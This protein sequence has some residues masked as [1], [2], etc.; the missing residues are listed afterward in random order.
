MP[1]AAFLIARQGAAP[2]A[3]MTL[4]TAG[5]LLWGREGWRERPLCVLGVNRVPGL[6]P[7]AMR[8]S[9]SHAKYDSSKH[10]EF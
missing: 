9:H 7:D 1:A 8:L 4:S 5:K 6:K 10:L 3:L 2:S